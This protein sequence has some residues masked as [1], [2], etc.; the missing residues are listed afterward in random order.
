MTRH[1]VLVT[2]HSAGGGRGGAAA[3][4][5]ED[6]LR[7]LGWR[8]RAVRSR[9]GEDA[10]R[11]GAE[12]DPDEVVVSL[13]GDGTHALVARGVAR[14]GAL[15]A[16]LPGGR[17][18][19]FVR[20]L[21]AS[22]DPVAGALALA[23]A[24]ERRIDLGDAGGVGFLGVVSIGYSALASRFA[25]TSRVRGPLAYHAA[26]VRALHACRPREYTITVDG[27]RRTWTGMELAIG[28]SGWYG[29][30]LHICPAADLADARL[31]VSAIA[32]SKTAFPAIM[33]GMFSGSHVN[34]PEV[35]TYRAASVEV[36]GRGEVWADGDALGALPIRVTTRPGA[37]RLLA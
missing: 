15:L 25:L 36:E 13:G 28:L 33:T 19:D 22:R 11:I 10:M 8:V 34:R 2:N 17:G 1:A 30:G 18:N 12:A 26:A 27:V 4:R 3:Q 31:D 20:A 35:Q 32:G 9:D 24:R 29:G 14:S 5:V 37:L 6:A 16:P 21:G 23:L 7:A